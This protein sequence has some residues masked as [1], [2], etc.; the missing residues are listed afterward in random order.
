[1]VTQ[2]DIIC[3]RI[4]ERMTEMGWVA[5]DLAHA[6]RTSEKTAYRWVSGEY[7]P[8]S[9]YIVSLGRSLEV[10]PLWLIGWTNDR[11]YGMD[12]ADGPV[13]RPPAPPKP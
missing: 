12:H 6:V 4:A 3:E 11:A 1:M 9:E 2:R 10:S 7:A 13:M 5:I 8:R